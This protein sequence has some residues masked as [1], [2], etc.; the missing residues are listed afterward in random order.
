M[1]ASTD[2]QQNRQ[3]QLKQ[4]FAEHLP[5]RI[6]SVQRRTLA[7][8]EGGWDINTLHLIFGEIQ[9]L[10]GTSGS[11]GLVRA[12]DKLFALEMHLSLFT[13]SGLV[14]D[15]DQTAEIQSLIGT[16]D[17][18]SG[19]SQ[20][21]TSSKSLRDASQIIV[22]VESQEPIIELSGLP[23]L[24]NVPNQVVPPLEFLPFDEAPESPIAAQ[25]DG[26]PG[27]LE[28]RS[29]EDFNDPDIER[30]MEG[31]TNLS[32]GNIAERLV[33]T[34]DHFKV[35]EADE[36][37]ETWHQEISPG[38]SPAERTL[39]E[40]EQP[41]EQSSRVR[42]TEENSNDVKLN[43]ES[44][45]S[46]SADQ[47]SGRS[48][49]V[50]FLHTAS[51]Q[52]DTLANDLEPQFEVH[53]FDNVEEFREIL[54]ALGPDAVMIDG[55]FFAEM[56]TLAPLIKRIRAKQNRPMP[57]VAFSDSTDIGTRLKVLRA[58]ADAFMS[59]SSQAAAVSQR[60]RELMLAATEEPYRVLI[61]ED[62]RSQAMFAQTILRKAGVQVQLERNPMQVLDTLEEFRPDLILMDLYMP[63]CDGMELTAIIRERDPFIN[64]PIV[65]LSG[66]SDTDKHFDAL[67]AGGDDFLA[68]PIRPRHLIQ[69]V[70][71]RVRRARQLGRGRPAGDPISDSVTGMVERPTLLGQ[72]NALLSDME[73]LNQE[74]PGGIV[75]VEVNKPYELKRKFGIKGF[76]QVTEEMALLLSHE[77]AREES[78]AR[79]G[80]NAYCILIP[81]R[82][83]ASLYALAQDLIA[84]VHQHNFKVADGAAKATVS[85]GVCMLSSQL[86]DAGAAI[87]KAERDCRPQMI[88]TESQAIPN[89]R[90]K[91]KTTSNESDQELAQLI[92]DAIENRQFQMLFQPIVSLH[93]ERTEQY[94]TLIRLPGKSGR[95]IAAAR[96]LPIAQEHGHLVKLDRWITSRALSV[97]DDRY[98]K[99]R[100]IFLFVNQSGPTVE[101]QA[102]LSWLLKL[103]ETRGVDPGSLAMEFKLP[104]IVH[105]LKATVGYCAELEKIG[106]HVALGGF[107]GSSAAFQVLEHLQAR[108]IK[109]PNIG[110]ADGDKMFVMD[111]KST[112]DRLHGQNRLVIVPAIE[113]AKTA[114]KL[115]P[116]GVDFIQGNFVQKPE[117]GLGYQF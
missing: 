51:A 23:A 117:S 94:Q 12:S 112:I 26:S 8:C 72:I 78:A 2:L 90:K 105:R 88:D 96:F 4:A 7:M 93:G 92:E 114:A 107:D 32:V 82:S 56:E 57:M 74:L 55:E 65:F 49:T 84:L 44:S 15:S 40:D 64:T 48:S 83:R 103:I 97:I 17:E 81:G 50:Y 6:A 39:V 5:P 95:P 59:S 34:E 101:V 20:Q 116:T 108:Y 102:N 75:Y 37:G 99:S 100:P 35:T 13:E 71:N 113:D 24:A 60:L 3:A 104:E 67:L 115:W 53:S 9:Q 87:A 62:D 28:S 110:S 27:S 77:L 18:I 11:Y 111:L 54:G 61:I 36:I 70:T 79:Y 52:M 73:H 80:D 91:T 29:I 89:T 68:K 45:V 19:G 31:D 85:T 22:P 38:R 21:P 63:D 69:A 46:G 76:E 47:L 25:E 30:L 33:S 1:A 66:E 106:V 10:A 98:R 16:L 41:E 43:L 109:L 14:P 86:A 42:D 58:G